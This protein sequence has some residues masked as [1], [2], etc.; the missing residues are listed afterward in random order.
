M[1]T[2][3]VITHS[4]F[5]SIGKAKWFDAYLLRPDIM[6]LFQKIVEDPASVLYEDIL[7]V[8]EFT[9]SVYGVDSPQNDLLDV[10]FDRLTS[11]KISSFRS[12]PPSPGAAIMQLQGSPHRSLYMGQST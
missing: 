9:L 7:K 3:G 12:L 8:T 4:V 11:K 2:L 1:L 6:N 10:R 5:F